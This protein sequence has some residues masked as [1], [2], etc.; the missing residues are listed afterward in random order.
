MGSSY[1][2]TVPEYTDLIHR[3][4]FCGTGSVLEKEKLSVKNL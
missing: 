2:S 4:I 3:I 1:N